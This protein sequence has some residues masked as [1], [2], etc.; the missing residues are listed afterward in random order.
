[1]QML[2]KSFLMSEK[3][4]GPHGHNLLKKGFLR[5]KYALN[6]FLVDTTWRCTSRWV[7][8]LPMQTLKRLWQNV[9]KTTVLKIHIMYYISF[10]TT[11]RSQKCKKPCKQCVIVYI[12]ETTSRRKKFFLL[13]FELDQCSVHHLVP[14]LLKRCD[15]T[16]ATI[17]TSWGQLMVSPH[18]GDDV[19]AQVWSWSE[20]LSTYFTYF[21][22]Y[23]LNGES[24][25]VPIHSKTKN[26]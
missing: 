13:V 22:F 26:N 14:F 17:D 11:E 2:C 21:L 24:H 6:R 10:P 18:G 15:Q 12:L 20:Y 19:L 4:E 3:F 1:M 16:G 23:L 5:V 25:N 7:K 8:A 9:T